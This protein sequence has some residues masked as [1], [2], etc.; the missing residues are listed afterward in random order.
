MLSSTKDTRIAS[1]LPRNNIVK[2]LKQ[3]EIHQCK[4]YCQDTHM[5]IHDMPKSNKACI[6]NYS[7]RKQTNY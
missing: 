2:L 5:E 1:K 6:G 4:L 7:E 3:P